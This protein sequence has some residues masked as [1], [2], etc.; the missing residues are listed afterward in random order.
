MTAYNRAD[1][2]KVV[3]KLSGPMGK[4][5]LGHAIEA[6]GKDLQ[7]VPG[8]IALIVFSDGEDIEDAPAKTAAAL[9]NQYGDR[10]CI[11]TVQLGNSPMGRRSWRALPR[12]ASAASLSKVTV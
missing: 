3:E 9:K 12:P 11:Y 5:P 8:K 6:A 10:I 4:T 1:L 7:N 2:G